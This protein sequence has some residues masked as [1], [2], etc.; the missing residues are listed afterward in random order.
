MHTAHI[1]LATVLS[2]TSDG[3]RRPGPDDTRAGW[4]DAPEAVLPSSASSWAPWRLPPARE[5]SSAAEQA[6]SDEPHLWP[7]RGPRAHSPAC[8]HPVHPSRRRRRSPL[9]HLAPCSTRA[10]ANSPPPLQRLHGTWR[11]HALR[12]ALQHALQYAVQRR[13]RCYRA[14]LQLI[15]VVGTW[16]Q[17]GR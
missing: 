6:T 10:N 15:R 8:A 14:A 12:F 3:P 7:P 9:P 2:A 1:R 4:A 17:G 16:G 13:W 11:V 5:R